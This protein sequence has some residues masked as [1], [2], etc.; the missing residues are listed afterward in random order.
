MKRTVFLGI[1]TALMAMAADPQ[2]AGPTLGYVYDK[3]AGGVR[4]IAGIPG[5]SSFGDPVA[6]D[7]LRPLAVSSAARYAVAIAD[8]GN[9]SIVRL[10]TM[11]RVAVDGAGTSPDSALLSSSGA[12]LVLLWKD[13]NRMQVIKGLPDRPAVSFETQLPGTPSLIAVDDAGSHA[14]FTIRE[15]DVDTVYTADQNGA[16]AVQKA[17]QI[18]AV[19]FVRGS[20]DALFADSAALYRVRDGNIERLSD[21]SGVV[22]LLATEKRALVATSD[23]VAFLDLTDLTSAAVKCSCTVSTLGALSANVFRVNDAM[24]SPLWI[25]DTNGNDARFFFVPQARGSDE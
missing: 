19:A 22:G 13:G 20:S 1:L 25:L 18:S 17:D 7:G 8:D 12:A 16:S 24:D 5:A 15:G 2:V 10:A 4:R 9:F 3:D 23:A 14:A 11:E 6:L 21:F